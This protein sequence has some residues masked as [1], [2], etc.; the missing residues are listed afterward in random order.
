MMTLFFILYVLQGFFFGI[1]VSAKIILHG[2]GASLDSQ[3]YLSF[4]KYPFF[5]KFMFAPL[6]DFVPPILL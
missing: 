5:F 4:A 1:A 3:F 6:L 2:K